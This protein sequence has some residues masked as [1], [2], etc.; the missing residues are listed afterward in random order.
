MSAIAI[1]GGGASGLIAAISAARNGSTVTVY[2]KNDR[3]GKKLIA[4]G[5][6]RCNLS[7]ANAGI[8]DYHGEDTSFMENAIN[9]FWVEETLNFFSEAGLLTKTEEDGKIYPYCDRAG[10]VLDILRMELDRLGVTI[11]CGFDV[12]DVIRRKTV[13]EIV[14]YKETNGSRYV[15]YLDEFF[16]KKINATRVDPDKIYNNN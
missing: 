6:G 12:K 1:I 11:N 16:V 14:P 7:N 4:T 15:S 13:F 3:P 9:V 8:N 5:N 2:E 10:A